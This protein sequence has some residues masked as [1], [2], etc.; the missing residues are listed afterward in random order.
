MNKIFATLV[1]LAATLTALAQVG[2]VNLN[3]NFT[4]PEATSKAYVLGWDGLPM[5]KA[6]GAVE[7]VD[8]L[9]NVIKAGGFGANGLFFLGVTEIPGTTPGGAGTI[10]IRAWDTS[11][12]STY[13]TA[14]YRLQTIVNLTGLGGGAIPPPSLGTAGDFR[15]LPGVPEPTAVS[16][17]VMGMMG[18]FLCTRR[19]LRGSP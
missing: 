8:S 9:G 4:P 18:L 3:N 5:A 12:G 14:T 10:T 11:T 6:V 19:K 15:G 7:I 16:L 17:A 13:G 2:N 1:T